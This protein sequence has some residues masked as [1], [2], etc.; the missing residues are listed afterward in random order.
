MPVSDSFIDF[1]KE[2][3]APLGV[4][5]V[6]K[7]FGGAGIYCNGQIFGIISDDV[8]YFKVDD[9][10]RPAFEAEA[11]GPFRY[12]LKDGEQVMNSYWRAPERLFDEPDDFRAW[13]RT[14][15]GVSRRA[16]TEKSKAKPKPRPATT[17]KPKRQPPRR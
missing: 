10:T 4:I 13:A 9:E 16:G 2:N 8:L 11:T 3:L 5:S 14:A 15:L 7:M 6:R 1:L 17:A 12:P